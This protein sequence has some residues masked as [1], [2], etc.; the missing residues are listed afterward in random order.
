MESTLEASTAVEPANE[1]ANEP[2]NEPAVTPAN[3]QAPNSNTKKTRQAPT[4]HIDDPV[5]RS[6]YFS[7]SIESVRHKLA[8]LSHVTNA[9]IMLVSA[10]EAGHL[11]VLASRDFKKLA[12]E[13]FIVDT[14]KAVRGST[15]KNHTISNN[16]TLLTLDDNKTA[17]KRTEQ[18]YYCKVDKDGEIAAE[19]HNVVGEDGSKK[20]IKSVNYG[21]K[22]VR[23]TVRK[24]IFNEFENDLDISISQGCDSSSSS[25]SKEEEV[26]DASSSS[27]DVAEEPVR[28][29]VRRNKRIIA[30][31][32]DDNNN[33]NNNVSPEKVS[34]KKQKINKSK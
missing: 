30:D 4:E 24:N 19:L 15:V 18:L 12:T 27:D 31:D 21:T 26:S 23:N 14:F 10:T 34:N 16:V 29:E 20:Q 28:Q 17:I 6:R 1:Q 11:K 32:D 2:A 8:L 22:R 25:V 9:S 5:E 13:K 33:N 7:K 3:E